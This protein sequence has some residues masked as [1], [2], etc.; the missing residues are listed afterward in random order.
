M[1]KI[2]FLCLSLSLVQGLLAQFFEGT[3]KAT[4]QTEKGNIDYTHFLRND[5]QA[6]EVSMMLEQPVRTRIFYD[7]STQQ[8][9]LAWENA[10]QKFRSK[11]LNV[12][13]ISATTKLNYDMLQVKE[14]AEYQNILGHTCRK[15]IFDFPTQKITCWV[16]PDINVDWATY[17]AYQKDDA[18]A[19]VLMLKGIKGYMLSAEMEQK[20]PLQITRYKVT[21]IEEKRPENAVFE[22]GEEYKEVK[23]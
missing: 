22:V 23:N 15:Y 5:Q 17:T 2:F 12:N 19:N 14:T 13:A 11:W 16:A 21:S 7:K 4:L 6:T 20:M 18:A 3:I 10:G 8:I 9:R 1:K